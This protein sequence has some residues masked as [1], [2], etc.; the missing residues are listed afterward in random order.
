M[1]ASGKPR[2]CG[3]LGAASKGRGAG[4]PTQPY[5][6][7]ERPWQQVPGQ[8]LFHAKGWVKLVDEHQRAAIHKRLGLYPVHLI[9]AAGQ[10]TTKGILALPPHLVRA[11]RLYLS[12]H[13]H[14]LL[15]HEVTVGEPVMALLRQLGA[16]ISLRDAGIEVVLCEIESR[17]DYL[18][19]GRAVLG[20]RKL[21][22]LSR[23]SSAE[24][25]GSAVENSCSRWL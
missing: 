24:V 3:R 19:V 13:P 22:V 11:G 9:N 4:L 1:K 6:T 15:P 25:V 20:E 14:H 21:Q 7:N 12:H 10:F 23:S 5:M 2:S 17:W 8:S 18:F 16:N